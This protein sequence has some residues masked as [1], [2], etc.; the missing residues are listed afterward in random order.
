MKRTDTEAKANA[1]SIRLMP[2]FRQFPMRMGNKRHLFNISNSS[3]EH[4]HK[5]RGR[6]FGIS[7]HY[8]KKILHQ[9]KRSQ[10]KYI[11][12][13]GTIEGSIR[14]MQGLDALCPVLDTAH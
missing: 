11:N 6:S 7:K 8:L 4:F 5:T 13:L 10:C 14:K 2:F 9:N 12:D 3:F 1:M